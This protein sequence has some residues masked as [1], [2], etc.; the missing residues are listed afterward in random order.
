MFRRHFCSFFVPFNKLFLQVYSTKRVLTQTYS[1]FWCWILNILYPKPETFRPPP[2]Y[3]RKFF[4]VPVHHVQ[5]SKTWRI[6]GSLLL[7]RRKFSTPRL[8]KK[9]LQ[10][11]QRPLL[12]GMTAIADR[13]YLKFAANSLTRASSMY[14]RVIL[15]C[16]VSCKI[17]VH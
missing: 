9:H 4:L 17:D 2:T 1:F 3:N 5:V 14:M 7:S 16:P 6:L 11:A 10:M 15:L 13:R 8:A 12:K